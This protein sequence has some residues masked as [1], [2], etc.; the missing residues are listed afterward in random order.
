MHRILAIG[1]KTRWLLL[2]QEFHMPL[3]HNLRAHMEM[4]DQ[5]ERDQL[6]HLLNH[7][8]EEKN[9]GLLMLML[10]MTGEITRL[11]LLTLE[12][13]TLQLFKLKLRM[14]LRDQHHL[15]LLVKQDIWEDLQHLLLNHSLEVRSSG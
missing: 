8:L 15:E 10:L 14:Y 11:Q 4:L 3:Q 6:F 7:L 2:I 5:M 12:S 1:V 13:H 9:N